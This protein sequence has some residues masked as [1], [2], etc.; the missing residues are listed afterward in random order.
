MKRDIIFPAEIWSFGKHRRYYSGGDSPPP[1]TSTTTVQQQFSPEEAAARAKVQAEA[2]R[3]YN[4]TNPS[5]SSSAYPGA[6]PANFSADTVNAQNKLRAFANGKGQTIANE[7]GDALQFGLK[8]VLNPTSSPGFQASLDSATRRVGE[9]YTDPNGVL[10]QIRGNFT[11][12]D[13]G[14]S[15]T[16]EGIANGLAGRSYLNT[17][18]DVTGK[19]TSDAYTAGLDTFSKTLAFAPNAYNLETQPA[20]TEAA[21]GQQSEGQ[22]QA[23]LDYLSQQKQWG[24][25]APWLGL[26]NYANV[27]YGGS[28]PTSVTSG[29][30]STGSANKASP[31]GGALAGAAIGS[32]IM[33]GIGTGVGAGAGLLMSLFS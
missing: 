17:I 11:S 3:I 24:L 25:S 21:I 33:P 26:G 1:A 31:F 4:T 18:G 19:M 14:G 7:A 16:R 9:A 23:I 10:G 13:S 22:Q 2:E 20:I 30:A 28:N 6:A 29:V 15:G 32:S 8:D 12:G 27:V 5:L